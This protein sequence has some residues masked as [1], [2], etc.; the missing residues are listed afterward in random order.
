MGIAGATFSECRLYRYTLTRIWDDAKP[1]VVFCGL[2]PSTADETHDDP[3]VRREIGFAKDWGM[4]GLIKVNACAWRSTDPKG[5]LTASDPVGKEN[6]TIIIR[7]AKRAALFVAAW[8]ANITMVGPA[9]QDTIRWHLREAGV[10]VHALKLTKGG[11]PGHPL[12][13]PKTLKP[14]EWVR[15]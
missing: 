7:E 2:N 11:F 4:G 9:W 12:Y 15:A 10:K 14:F 13:L 6:L 1:T 5:L 8:G 3:T